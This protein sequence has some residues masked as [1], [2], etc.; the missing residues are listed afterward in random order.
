VAWG[1]GVLFAS[2]LTAGHSVHAQDRGAAALGSALQGLG[3]N[4]RVLMIGA[5]PD[6]EDTQ[7][8]AWLSRGRHIETAYLSLTRGD[9][10]Q[11][12][13]GNELG[14]G[15]GVIRT[16]ELLAA[17]R[18]D[19]ARQYFTRA[20]DYGFSKNAQEAF[21][22]WP[23]DSLLLDVMT[24]VRA[25]KPHVIIAVFTGTPRDGHGQ[26]QASGIL[27]REVY[28]LS[29]DT[30]RFPRS[31]TA[32]HGAWTVSKFYRGTFFQ[33]ENATLTFNVGEYDPILGRSYAEIAAISRSQHRSQAF[34]S[35]QPLG[36]RTDAVQRE[37]SR[38]T[39]P[40]DAKT[41]R[42]LFD[43]I[44]TTW[45]RFRGAVSGAARSALDS[46]PSAFATAR[47]SFDAYAPEKSISALARIQRLLFA[48]CPS[49][50]ARVCGAGADSTDLSASATQA[51]GRVNS[52]LILAAGIAMEA[53]VPRELWGTSQ[54]VPVKPVLYNRGRTP[55][56]VTNAAAV[57]S[58]GSMAVADG[59]G[60]NGVLVAAD[61]TYTS[62][63]NGLRFA[64]NSVPRWLVRPRRGAMYD[65]AITGRDEASYAVNA[66]ATFEFQVGGAAVH[67]QAPIV[68]RFA[69]Q[70][71]GQITRPI[72]GVPEVSVLLD[73]Q[74]QYAPARVPIERDLR[75]ELRGAAE[76]PREV[77]L[78]VK[79]PAGLIA[80]SATR[81][82][83]VPAAGSTNTVTF[84]VRGQLP[85]GH[86]VIDVTAI[87][88]DRTF[89][90]G[91]TTID[92]EHIT[93]RRI[94]R[95]SRMSL[96]AV[97]IAAANGM[98]V[99][100]IAGVSDNSA[101]ALEQLGIDV[102]MIDPASLPNANLRGYTAVVIG[103][104]AY[105][106]QPA[107]VANN[108][109]LLDYARG[110]GTLVV[111]YGQ[112]EMQQPGI[113]PYPIT[114]NRPHDRVTDEN[115]P[116]T[117]LDTAAAILR[118]PNRITAKDFEGWI[119]DRSLYMPRTFGPEYAPILAM[120]DPGEQPS[121]G[122]LLI[123]PLGQGTYVYT[124]LAFFRQLPN[125]VPGAARLFVNLL[126]AKATRTA[127]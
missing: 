97:D 49:A 68:Y 37:A 116:V 86:H 121:R 82:V 1:L 23:H 42:T 27:S 117:V 57:L 108:R 30:V 54:E 56:R 94:Y 95:P 124:T 47:S 44:D 100:Y 40:G 75:V 61:S 114:I 87:E 9:G 96:E 83:T 80:D 62:S 107:L 52:A 39:V 118:A 38:V 19:G 78:E 71:L 15:L 111:Q 20:Y 14:E 90:E 32:G 77:R 50:S 99:G 51:L 66:L 2:L 13:I 18:I 85:A 76:Q 88:G 41:E 73:Q 106:T 103:P 74:L 33:R 11:N 120:N 125:G 26:H 112:Y 123:A 89:A 91:Y 69:D 53:N 24:V 31:A 127:Q 4:T 48:I 67:A 72:A 122:A 43:G 34:G 109:R 28:D 7:I 98:R 113:M 29:A 21:T 92:Y 126:S 22:Q 110:G 79:L 12:V 16:E 105:E 65:Y 115:A 25:F 17:R 45:A 10:G 101:A 59:M 81:T 64:N 84:K 104:R 63:F 8:V 55:I 5:H 58:G 46:L 102:T 6:D 93:A 119:Q 60:G 70:V 3:V 36:A 35:L